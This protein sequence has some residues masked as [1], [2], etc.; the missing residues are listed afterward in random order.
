MNLM[1]SSSS[2]LYHFDMSTVSTWEYYVDVILQGY[3]KLNWKTNLNLPDDGWCIGPKNRRV[4]DRYGASARVGSAFL[5]ELGELANFTV[6]GSVAPS[7][8]V[9]LSFWMALS[10]STLWSKR[11]KPTPFDSPAIINRHNK[12]KQSA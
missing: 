9:P 12:M 1:A 5:L 6:I 3:D 8:I 2:L 4:G 11:I 7:G 10:A